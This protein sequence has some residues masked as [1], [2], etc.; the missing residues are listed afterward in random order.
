VDQV[1]WE[2]EKMIL[3]AVEVELQAEAYLQAGEAYQR[4][5]AYVHVLKACFQAEV[6][7]VVTALP[8]ALCQVQVEDP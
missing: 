2:V 1:V 8:P 6:A 3:R 5:K 4:M 7:W